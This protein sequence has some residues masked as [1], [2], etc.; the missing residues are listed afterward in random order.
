[1]EDSN[2]IFLIWHWNADIAMRSKRMH[3]RVKPKQIKK[4]IL[5]EHLANSNAFVIKL[6]KI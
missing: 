2:G 6:L 1:M 5:I 4:N 3:N